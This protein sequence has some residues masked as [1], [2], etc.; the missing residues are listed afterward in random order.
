MAEIKKSEYKRLQLLNIVGFSGMVVVNILANALPINNLDTGQIADMFPNLFTPAGFTFSIWGLIYLLLAIFV[1]YQGKGV[2]GKKV[3]ELDYVQRI[4]Y[5]F[6]TSCIFNI[7]WIFTWHYLYIGLSLVTMIIL[8]LILLELY[9][10]LNSEKSNEKGEFITRI[11]FS[12]Y[13]GWITIAT[14]A[15]VTV[16]LVDIN[17]GGF[18]LTDVFWM[19]VITIVATA[20]VIL[21]MKKNR[22]PF[23]SLVALWA[24]FGIIYERLTADQVEIAVVIVVAL[25]M[26]AI[27]SATIMIIKNPGKE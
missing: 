24:F 2:Y 10:K 18:G 8:L 22:D 21:F 4:G 23:Y 1:V 16:F 27:A 15:N 9:K 11:A 3:K 14:V 19:V 17:W 7:I 12:I 13:L 25:C 6:F 5:L 26:I 20:I